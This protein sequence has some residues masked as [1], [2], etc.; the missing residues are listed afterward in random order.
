MVKLYSKTFEPYISESQIQEAI[1]QLA[2]ELKSEYQ[3]KK[4]LFVGVLNGSFMFM[5]DLMKALDFDL[6]MSFVKF[7][8]YEGTESTG[9][10]N[11]LIGFNQDL[12]GRDVVVVE[13]IVDTGNTLGKIRDSL[14]SKEV[15]SLKIVT[16]LLK[17]E[18]FKNKYPV[19][20]VGIEIPNH[21]V[22]GYG[23]DY[24]E[25]GRNLKEIYKISE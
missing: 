13:D 4:P 2:I 22:V 16:L 7:S 12:K 6:E 9:T 15:N 25:L 8:S 21:F 5:S 17:P 20:Y 1:N 14:K 23:L 18:V 10:V 11:E 24:D 3:N 19:D